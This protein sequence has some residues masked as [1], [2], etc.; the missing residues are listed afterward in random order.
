VFILERV[1]STM[2]QLIASLVSL[3]DDCNGS[4]GIIF[5]STKAGISMFMFNLIYDNIH[6][7]NLYSFS[8]NSS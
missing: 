6:S 7:V 5:T 2:C 1:L 3:V 4:P 8:F